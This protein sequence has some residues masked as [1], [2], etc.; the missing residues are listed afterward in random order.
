M[1]CGVRERGCTGE[2]PEEVSAGRGAGQTAR[3]GPVTMTSPRLGRLEASRGA[4]TPPGQNDRT[5]ACPSKGPVTG[6]TEDKAGT[7]KGISL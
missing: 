7:A 6:A 5:K 2:G 1:A 3:R 4:A